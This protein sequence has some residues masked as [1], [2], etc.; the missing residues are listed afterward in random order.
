[1]LATV[2]RPLW[3]GL[4][5]GE[6]APLLNT[7]PVEIG[8]YCVLLFAACMVLH[9]EL[10][11]LR[12]AARS[13]TTFYLSVS[14]GGALGGLFVGIVAPVLFDDYY[15]LRLGLALAGVLALVAW[16]CRAPGIVNLRSIG[17]R[18]AISAGLIFV[19]TAGTNTHTQH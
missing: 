5:P 17:W 16:G 1:M 11:R 10:Y 2:A 4:W 12:P 9:G 7:L 15:E 8:S 13:L 6:G 18:L 19:L 3:E 14:G